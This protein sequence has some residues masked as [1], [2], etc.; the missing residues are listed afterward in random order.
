MGRY[1]PPRIPD[2]N[3]IN[4]SGNSGKAFAGFTKMTYE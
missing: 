3:E 4:F 1:G 2:S